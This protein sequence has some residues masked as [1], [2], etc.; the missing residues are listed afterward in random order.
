[1][2]SLASFNEPG[3]AD[4]YKNIEEYPVLSQV[5]PGYLA[6]RLPTAAPYVAEPV[7]AIL[8]DVQHNII[9]GITHWQSPN[10]FAYFPSSGS[11]AG[12][13]GEM[14]STG[15]NVV[16]FNWISSPAATELES[17]V[18]DW[19][20]QMLDLPRDFLF[21]GNGGGVLQGTTCEAILC[22]VTAA[23]DRM[24]LKVGRENIGKLVVYASD[25]THS[26]LAKAAKIAG[27]DP[28]NFRAIKTKRSAAFG[29]SPES[30][31]HAISTDVKA[32]LI[33]LYLCATIGTT[34]TTAVDPLIPLCD[35]A[36]EYGMWV[37]VDAAYA[38]S[39]CICP[40]FRHFIDG[41]EGAD[42]FRSKQSHKITLD[43]SRIPPEQSQRLEPSGGLQ[44][45]AVNSEQ[46]FR[47]MKLWLVL[48]SYGVANLRN[49][50]RSHVKMAKRF[51]ELVTN[52]GRFEVVVPRYFAMVCF[53][54]S[55]SACRRFAATS[56]T[57]PCSSEVNSGLPFSVDSDKESF[58]YGSQNLFVVPRLSKQAGMVETSKPG[59]AELDVEDGDD[60]G[61]EAVAA[62]KEGASAVAPCVSAEEEPVSGTMENQENVVMESAAG[63]EE[64][65][66][67]NDS[68][69]VVD[70]RNTSVDEGLQQ[71]MVGEATSEGDGE[72]ES[73]REDHG[74]D[75]SDHFDNK[76]RPP[77][78]GQVKFNVD[79]AASMYGAGC[80][81]IMHTYS[82][83][84]RAM[85]SGPVE[86]DGADFA[87]I[88]TIKTALEIFI[89]AKWAGKEVLMVESDS[90][91]VLNWISQPL[92]RPWK[93][94]TLFEQID[95]LVK[96]SSSYFASVCS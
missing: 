26:A 13:L 68:E 73:M 92:L 34:S 16:G 86:N 96:V 10:Y 2:G 18:V 22:T 9:P 15:F 56:T 72:Q 44:R 40:E 95:R 5:E 85:F 41:V 8:R 75:Q 36:K 60:G 21:S 37:H 1:M 43:Q 78:P 87:E 74:L 52:D 45:L 19:L 82:G 59:C 90:Q 54:V 81:G 28:K 89:E 11:V 76:W 94:W 58:H 20:G 35:V 91:V 71:D 77:L 63:S 24:L 4:Y 3:N 67:S 61:S 25:Q 69:A 53:R 93:W 70:G 30:L 7:E 38:G 47:A 31:R 49:F 66:L 17:I 84:I 55:P 51:E 27:I 32:G 39:A 14:L 79:G 80:G 65:H 88:M 6:K 33:P 29:L 57:R 62:D 12:F 23:R 48:R 64:E 46:T 42:S 50:L 83:L